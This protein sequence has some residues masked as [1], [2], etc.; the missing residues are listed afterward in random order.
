MNRVHRRRCPELEDH[1]EVCLEE[2]VERLRRS[3]MSVAEISQ[4]MGV[5]ESWVEALISAWGEGS[6][7]EEKHA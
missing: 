6:P 5:D 1:G 2:E 3:G 7:A 4:M